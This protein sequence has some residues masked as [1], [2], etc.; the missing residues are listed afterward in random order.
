MWD[1]DNMSAGMDAAH[2]DYGLPAAITELSVSNNV[3]YISLKDAQG[4]VLANYSYTL[5]GVL[6]R[7][8]D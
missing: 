5:A 6:T 7:I 1:Q 3:L 4:S 8:G 2:A